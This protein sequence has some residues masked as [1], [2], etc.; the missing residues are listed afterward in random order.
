M[1]FLYGGRSDVQ[2]DSAQLLPQG[3]TM[4]G[5]TN[6]VNPFHYAVSTNSEVQVFDVSKTV[7]HRTREYTEGMPICMLFI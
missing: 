4:L 6:R 2:C 5:S 1:Q 3:G 7:M